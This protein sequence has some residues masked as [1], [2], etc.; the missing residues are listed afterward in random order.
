MVIPTGF[1]QVNLVFGGTGLPFGA[2]CTFGVANPEELSPSDIGLIVENRAD[3]EQIMATVASTTTLVGI[4]VKNG[5][6]STGPSA[7]VATSIPGEDS[8]GQA[9]PNVAWLFRKETPL[10]GRRGRGRM[11]VPGVGETRIDQ[12]GVIAEPTRAAMQTNWRNFF[13]E[14]TSSNLQPFLLHGESAS[15]P[16]APPT[17]ISTWFLDARVATQRR[18]L[19]R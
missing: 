6:N 11:Y 3:T 4:L 9:S 19:R 15:G 10:G 5:P 13:D 12:A 1:S 16:A 17:P 2:Q 8:V 18:R 14:L 7:E